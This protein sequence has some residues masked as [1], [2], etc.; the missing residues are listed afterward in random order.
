M[1]QPT[2]YKEP[3]TN[4]VNIIALITGLF[5]MKLQYNFYDVKYLH[6]NL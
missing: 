5:H 6:K 3:V 4:I 2:M 1:T